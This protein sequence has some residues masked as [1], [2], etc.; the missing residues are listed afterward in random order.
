[1]KVAAGTAAEPV[2]GAAYT[3]ELGESFANG[4][5]GGT[6]FEMM[7]CAKFT[8]LLLQYNNISFNSSFAFL[9]ESFKPASVSGRHGIL[10]RAADGSTKLS[11]PGDSTDVT[12]QV[13]SASICSAPNCRPRQISHAGRL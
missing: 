8:L 7:R 3:L 5:E 12:F 11:F 2:P 13:S 1:M 10:T 9:D 4:R 6:S